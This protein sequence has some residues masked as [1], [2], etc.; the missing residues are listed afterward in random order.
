MVKKSNKWL[1]ILYGNI[2]REEDMFFCTL[3]IKCDL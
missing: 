1:F 2:I 3:T